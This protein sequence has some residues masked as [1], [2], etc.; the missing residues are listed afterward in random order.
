M[1][2]IILL[3][4]ALC[5]SACI[6]N[7]PNLDKLVKGEADLLKE[8]NAHAELMADK[9]AEAIAKCATAP[10]VDG[11]MLGAV[12]LE[13]ASGKSAGSTPKRSMPAYTPP[14]TLLQQA[15]GFVRDA[16]PLVN[17][18]TGAAVAI[19][20]TRER[21]RTAR[22]NESVNAA[23]EVAIV[24]EVALAGT[25]AVRQMGAQPPT[26]QVSEGG[27]VNSGTITQVGGDAIEGDGNATRGGQNGHN[28]DEGAL[29]EASTDTTLEQGEGDLQTEAG[30][31]D[32]LIEEGPGDQQSPPTTIDNSDPGDDC[33]GSDC[34]DDVPPPSEEVP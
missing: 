6:P 17:V 19:D 5:L 15:G 34:G 27:I 33:T 7:D 9:R 31:G 1:L 11:C 20:G 13:L 12:A 28:V 2:R 32:L 4:A 21:E 22:H 25:N 29:V 16:A 18:L 8:D 26:Y 30:D 23:R 10:N 14:P 24:Q 3:S